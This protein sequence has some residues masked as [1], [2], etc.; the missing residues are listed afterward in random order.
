MY[1]IFYQ[2]QHLGRIARN[3]TDAVSPAIKQN[4]SSGYSVPGPRFQPYY[5]MLRVWDAGLSKP[6]LGD[7]PGTACISF[8]SAS[9]TVA[10]SRLRC[11]S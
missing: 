4:K 7:R 1:N 3:R 2:A 5:L 10:W 9:S 8:C 6:V 11:E